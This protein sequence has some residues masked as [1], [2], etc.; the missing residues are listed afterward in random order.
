MA[1]VAVAVSIR[2]PI[3]SL[4]KDGTSREVSR[5]VSVEESWPKSQF[6]CVASAEIAGQIP[7]SDPLERSSHSVSFDGLR[8]DLISKRPEV[9][10]FILDSCRDNPLTDGR[11]KSIPNPAPASPI[12][13]VTAK[14]GECSP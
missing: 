4:L 13:T 5:T 14:A 11:G 8:L 2:T 7:G 10:S 9:R 12:S 3:Y 6:D 1:V